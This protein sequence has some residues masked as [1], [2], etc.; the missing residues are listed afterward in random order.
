MEKCPAC[1]LSTLFT[2]VVKLGGT[3][4]DVAPMPTNLLQCTGCSSL[5]KLIPNGGSGMTLVQV[6]PNAEYGR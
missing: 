2:P 6:Q 3:G 5:V 1:S 4:M